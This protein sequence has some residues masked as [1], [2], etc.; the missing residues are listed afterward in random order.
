VLHAWDDH[1]AHPSLPRTLGPRLRAAGFEDVRAEAHAFA[2]TEFDE[3]T[4]YGPALTPFIAGFV[5]GH[6]D[7]TGDEAGRWL[8]DQRALGER[9]EFYFAIT[10]FCFVAQKSV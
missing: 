5:P 3:Q 7:V 8:A 10:Q 4:Y 1:L 2:T 6:R 9:G